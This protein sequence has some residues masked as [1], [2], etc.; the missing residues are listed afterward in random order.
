MRANLSSHNSKICVIGV[1][2]LGSVVSSCLADAGYSVVGM[3]SNRE[4]VQKLNAGIAP[5]YEPGLDEL[6]KRNVDSKRLSFTTDLET[7][8][9]GARYVLITFDTPVDAQDEVDVSEIFAIA[10]ALGQC[11]ENG[12]VVVVSSQVPVG[13][14]DKMKS[15]ITES[16]RSRG[17]EF[18]VA[19]SPENLRL[20]RAIECFRKPDRIVIGADNESTLDR[21][22]QLF[23]VISAPKLRMGL[24]SAEM[25]KH[26]LN[27]YLATCIS[28]ANEVAN[29]CDMV[30]AD[31]MEV[32]EGLHSDHRVGREAPLRPGLGFSGGHLARDLKI[33]RRLGE[34]LRHR[35]HL[36][37]GVLKVNEEQNKA[38]AKKLEKILGS[39]KDSSITIL[40][41]TYKP[42]T[43]TL[44]RSAALEI[45]RDLVQKGAIVKAHDPK[46]SPEEIQAHKEFRFYRDPYEAVEGSDALVI[47]TEWPE[48]RQLDFDAIKAKMKRPVLFD[49]TNMLDDKSLREKGFDYFTIGRGRAVGSPQWR[50]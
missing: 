25:T 9:K 20:G 5:L 41:L 7:A 33:L 44:H 50:S 24:K 35:T 38:V 37:D 14:C 2:H 43:S 42:G 8:V 26:A 45:I 47:V 17:I 16:A 13:T 4:R 49:P 6:L 1:W 30:G 40:G 36:I 22:E 12:A 23:S 19:C 32:S 29:L 10:H 28:F 31:A 18:D 46:A 3:D 34:E 21:V 27:C 11:L 39:L 48:Y 15:T